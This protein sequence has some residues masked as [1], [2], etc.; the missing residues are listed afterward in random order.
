[1]TYLHNQ[2][3]L[4]I[5]SISALIFVIPE[6]SDRESRDFGYAIELCCVTAVH[7]G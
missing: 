3:A 4:L 5:K 6:L 1:M 7:L 2:A